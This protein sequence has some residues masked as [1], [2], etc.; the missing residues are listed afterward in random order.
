MEMK[1]HQIGAYKIYIMKCLFSKKSQHQHIH[2]YTSTHLSLTLLLFCLLIGQ[3]KEAGSRN[4][5]WWDDLI[6]IY[7]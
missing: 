4:R 2:A 7:I 6:L 3:K 5:R 1:N